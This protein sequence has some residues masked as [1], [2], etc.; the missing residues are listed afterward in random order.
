MSRLPTIDDHDEIERHLAEH[1]VTQ[2]PAA[3][4]MCLGETTPGW[5]RDAERRADFTGMVRRSH[6]DG[7]RALQNGLAERLGA[8]RLIP[9]HTKPARKK[10]PSVRV[11]CRFFD[12]LCCACVVYTEDQAKK[13]IANLAATYAG[14]GARFYISHEQKFTEHSWKITVKPLLTRQL[15]RLA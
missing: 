15:A 4:A 7:Q 14:T 12:K 11:M 13:A 1:G 10:L 5:R 9:A 8:Q 2:L 3:A 6:A